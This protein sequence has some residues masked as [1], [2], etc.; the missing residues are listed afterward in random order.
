MTL[1]TIL[2]KTLLVDDHELIRLGVEL[3]LKET[4]LF[5][6]IHHASN[7]KDAVERSRNHEY[8]L[9]FMDIAMPMMDGIKATRLIYTLN[10]DIKILALSSISDKKYICEMVEAGA[11]GYLSKEADAEEISEA[12]TTVCNG[13]KYFSKRVA[14]YLLEDQPDVGANT[15]QQWPVIELA[16]REIDVLKLICQE[17]TTKEISAFLCVS[18]KTIEKYRERLLEKTGAKNL[19]GLVMF[20]VSRGI[21][22]V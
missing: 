17:F 5:K 4:G 18:N 2:L 7:G 3:K 14:V 16:P 21:V 13:Q 22:T 8:D 12:V 6:L 19:A 11:Y 1:E 20:A 10:K 9:I 15:R